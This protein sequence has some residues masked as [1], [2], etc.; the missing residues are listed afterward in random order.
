MTIVDPS[1]LVTIPLTPPNRKHDQARLREIRKKLESNVTV[2]EIE[3]Y[4]N[5]LLPH[6]DDLSSGRIIVFMT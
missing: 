4:F 2:K 3:A 1:S 5:E 6:A